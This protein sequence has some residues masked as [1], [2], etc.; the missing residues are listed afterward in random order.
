M[1]FQDFLNE[2]EQDYGI[3][4]YIEYKSHVDKVS[5]DEAASHSLSRL[6]GGIQSTNNI[7]I[8]T[9]FRSKEHTLPENRVRNRLLAADIRQLGWGYTPVLG[10]FKETYDGKEI[11]TQEESFF[12]N[13]AGDPKQVILRVADLLKKYQQE[14][15][16]VKP[17]DSDQAFYIPPEGEPTLAGV[18][19]AD[20]KLLAKY[21]TRMRKGPQNRQFVFKAAGDDSI[22]T[23]QGVDAYFKEKGRIQ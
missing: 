10:G 11:Y 19:H 15:A 18:W 23:R 6:F 13:A 8:I 3:A 12:V 22:M 4:R 7:V 16:I 21:Y 17:S 2:R 1:S 14:F 9:A 5:L 20:P